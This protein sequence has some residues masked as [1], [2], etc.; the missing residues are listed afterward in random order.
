MYKYHL[1]IS[2]MYKYHLV[3]MVKNSF[4]FVI[5]CIYLVKESKTQLETRNFSWASED[6]IVV[7]SF[8]RRK[9]S[10]S[11]LLNSITNLHVLF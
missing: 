4:I 1:Q 9:F 6:Y 3:F 10:L 11:A 8:S 2:L 5:Y 7:F